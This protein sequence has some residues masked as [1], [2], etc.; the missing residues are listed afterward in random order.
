M[1]GGGG[2]AC[3]EGGVGGV[4]HLHPLPPPLVLK[5]KKNY[6]HA[7]GDLGFQKGRP[8]ISSQQWVWLLKFQGVCVCVC[9]V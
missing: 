6:T 8:L 5:K 2:G 7:L 3:S 9:V 4:D 1:G